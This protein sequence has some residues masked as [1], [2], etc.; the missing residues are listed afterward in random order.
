MSP[1]MEG[2]SLWEIEKESSTHSILKSTTKGS[3][4]MVE[5]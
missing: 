2:A 4:G 3:V 5:K 1:N